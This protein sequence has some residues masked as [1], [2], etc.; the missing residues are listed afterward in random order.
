MAKKGNI[1][2]IGIAVR[3]LEAAVVVFHEKLGLPL[4]EIKELPDRGIKIAFLH[5]G[6]TLVELMA[7]LGEDSQI[8]KFLDK[9][10]EGIHHMCFE[11]DDV[12]QELDR[13]SEG[14]VRTLSKRPEVGAEGLPM[15]F[16]HPKS[17][18]GVLVEI[19]QPER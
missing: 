6:E 4:R 19:L 1:N 3:D 15:A 12:A 16:L 11:V 2:H 9:R 13:L 18:H 5:A 7:P 14:G 10:G 17:T 8:S